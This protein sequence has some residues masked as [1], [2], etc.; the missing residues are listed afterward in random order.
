MVSILVSMASFA[1]PV[2]KQT[3]SDGSIE[4]SNASLDRKSKKTI[5]YKTN[6]NQIP[7]FTNS[8]PTHSSYEILQFDCFACNP[9]STIDWYSVKLN[10]TAYAKTV[11]KVAKK[12]QVDPA[13]VRA[14]IHA[15]SAF[16]PKIKSNKGA[17]GLMQ[18]MPATAKELGVKDALNPEQNIQGGVKYLAQLLRQFNGDIRLA[19]AAYNAGPGAVKK[20]N[21]IPPYKETKVYVERVMILHQRYKQTI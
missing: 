18:L 19:T 1:A 16:K 9:N 3:N 2:V 12:N 15:E 7:T 5:I 4:F 13:L 8:K 11:K 14:L 21:G 20:Y 17:M 6:N 10:R